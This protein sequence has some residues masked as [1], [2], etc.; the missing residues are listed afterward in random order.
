MNPTIKVHA[1]RSYAMSDAKKKKKAYLIGNGQATKW[2]DFNQRSMLRS[3]LYICVFKEMSQV[4][5]SVS[6]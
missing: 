5:V 2:G 1:L 6:F 3:Y 4:I